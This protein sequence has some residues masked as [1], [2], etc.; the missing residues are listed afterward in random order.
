RIARALQGLAMLGFQRGIGQAAQQFGQRVLGIHLRGRRSRLPGGVLAHATAAPCPRGSA[1]ATLLPLVRPSSAASQRPV[2]TRRSRS[3]PVSMPRPWSMYATSSLATLPLAPVAY[4][5][6]P[7]PD[8]EESTTAT[9]SS[10]QASR[11]AS[12]CP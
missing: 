4:G 9:P 3:M 6:P 10:R 12:A 8:T 11:F 5:Q 2:S 7:V 1:W